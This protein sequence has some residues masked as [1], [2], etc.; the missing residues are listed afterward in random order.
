MGGAVYAVY[1]GDFNSHHSNWGYTSDDINGLQLNRW[2]ERNNLWL[3]FDAK[4]RG[5]FHSARW[6]QDYNPDLT[7]AS[8]D[9]EHKPLISKR[10]VLEN[11]PRSQH[12]QI[13]ISVGL[14][15]PLVNSI[16]KPRWNFNLADWPL[17]QEKLDHSTIHQTN[18]R[19][20]QSVC[21]CDNRSSETIYSERF[22]K[23][24]RTVLEC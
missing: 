20:L 14:E 10:T 3:L 5:T 18:N 1:A 7:F 11:F 24:I 22:Q 8:M 16:Q 9:E 19:K 6:Q 2:S 21:W 15:F 4:D 13:I 23:G 12:R 17:F